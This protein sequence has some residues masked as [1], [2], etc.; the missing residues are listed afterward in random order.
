[1]RTFR[2]NI[3]VKS[4]KDS[5]SEKEVADMIDTMLE[6]YAEINTNVLAYIKDCQETTF[7]YMVEAGAANK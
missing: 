5:V 3:L 1:M 6:R 7:P 2:V 4:W